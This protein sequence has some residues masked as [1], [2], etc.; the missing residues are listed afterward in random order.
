MKIHEEATESSEIVFSA[1]FNQI[2]RKP[3][4]HS[5]PNV[6][7]VEDQGFDIDL[8]PYFAWALEIY[9]TQE[10]IGPDKVFL[11]RDNLPKDDVYNE[12]SSEDEENIVESLEKDLLGFEE[13]SKPSELPSES[14]QKEPEE[15]KEPPKDS[16]EE[17]PEEKEKKAIEEEDPED[18]LDDLLEDN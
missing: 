13:E 15:C 12:Q 6:H 11:K 16:E 14:D 1:V 2:V 4:D 18:L 8:D 9:R 17:K 7:I 3:I 5:L 10:D